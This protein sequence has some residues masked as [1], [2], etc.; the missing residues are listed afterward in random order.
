MINLANHESRF[1]LTRQF[2]VRLNEETD[3]K[4]EHAVE[5]P[6]MVA[7]IVDMWV[8]SINEMNHIYYLLIAIP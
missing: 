8:S 3:F 6:E 2:I 5:N 4:H 7:S 1:F